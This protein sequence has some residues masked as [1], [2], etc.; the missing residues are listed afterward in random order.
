MKKLVLVL[1]SFMMLSCATDDE[2][3]QL[4]EVHFISFTL[5]DVDYVV[6][7]YVVTIDSTDEWNRMVEVPFDNATK[8]LRFTVE[9]EETNQIN[10]LLFEVDDVVW[11]SD[12]TY[13][14]RETSITKH[15]DSNMEGTF[16]VTFE[17]A[18]RRGIYRFTN[19]VINIEF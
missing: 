15:T 1:L 18:S 13:G 12:P 14:N 7:E 8:T 5:N 3:L 6:T 16:R 17:D 11:E 19:G 2:N 4:P 9:V 10:T